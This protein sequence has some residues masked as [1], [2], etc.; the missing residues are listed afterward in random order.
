M[1]HFLSSAALLLPFIVLAQKTALPE[2]KVSK[3]TQCQPYGATRALSRH[4]GSRANRRYYYG[5]DLLQP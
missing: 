1:K 3:P 5:N 2:V 4:F